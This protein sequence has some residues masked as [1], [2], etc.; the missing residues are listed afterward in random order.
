MVSVAKITRNDRNLTED[1]DRLW[2]E[3]VQVLDLETDIANVRPD[4]EGKG[5]FRLWNS[6]TVA[7]QA[8]ILISAAR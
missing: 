8:T 2:E 1:D 3:M 5:T 4:S 6:G 7:G